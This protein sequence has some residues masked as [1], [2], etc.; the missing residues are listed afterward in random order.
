MFHFWTLTLNIN[1]YEIYRDKLWNIMNIGRNDPLIY[2]IVKEY[3]NFAEKLRNIY[4]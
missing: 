4:F 1:I 2:L 3:V